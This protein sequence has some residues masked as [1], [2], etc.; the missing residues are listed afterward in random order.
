MGIEKLKTFQFD[1]FLDL[2]KV[3]KENL[4]SLPN[5]G[6][7]LSEKLESIDIHEKS[8]L[9]ILGAEKTFIK[10]KTIYPDACINHLYALEGAIQ[11]IRWHSLSNK[12]K[13]E[14]L[15]FYQSFQKYKGAVQKI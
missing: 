10:L 7:N 2:N 9:V 3:M 15:Q 4:Q 11:G 1:L 6:K 5:L 13:K 14:L 12:R 8:H